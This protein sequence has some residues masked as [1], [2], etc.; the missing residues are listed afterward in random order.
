MPPLDTR[1][2]LWT[3]AVLVASGTSGLALIR[4]FLH[5]A[6]AVP[7]AW[8]T[9]AVWGVGATM[10]VGSLMLL[11]LVLFWRRWEERHLL[12]AVLALGGLLVLGPATAK[13][14]GRLVL[15]PRH[16]VLDSVLQV[17]V[18]AEMLSQGRN[19]YRETYHGT[20]LET[21]HDGRDRFPL[22]HM[23][24]PPV[25][26]LV[27]APL[28]TA[29]V[30]LFGVYDSRFLLIPAWIAA[31]AVAMRAW[32]GNPWRPLL[33]A[34]AF[35]NP[36]ILP[37]LHVGRWD[38]LALL[39]WTLALL[40]WTRG[41]HSWMAALLGLMAGVKPV[42]LAAGVFGALAVVRDARDLRRWS[43]AWLG[44]FVLPL[45]PFLVWDA[46]ALWE[47]LVAAPL[48]LGGRPPILVDA[49]PY[50]GAWVVKLLGGRAPAW[51]VQIPVTLATAFVMGREVKERRTS[52]A[53]GLALGV[54]LAT[55]FYFGSY[56]DAAYVGFLL[57]MAAVGIGFDRRPPEPSAAAAPN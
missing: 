6:D 40:A 9:L 36:L 54:T 38:T 14:A 30:G 44:A 12:G 22:H 3:V 17:E 25:P 55:F 33:L 42:F 1:V 45:L 27:T 15:G 24:Y 10:A 20:A 21:W 47:D 46:P 26:V 53:A 29:S 39:I 50:G 13:T 34:V 4:D 19:P 7:P 5:R 56:A 18:A 51:L 8:R 41:A 23:V 49:G 16:M 31:F 28:R 11:A 37:N 43:A 2:R 35:L 32:R 52:T 57:S 48:A